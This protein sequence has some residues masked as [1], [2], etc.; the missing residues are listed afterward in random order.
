MTD[1]FTLTT[2]E[3]AQ[4]M[5]KPLSQNGFECVDALNLDGGSS[6][7]LSVKVGGFHLNISSLRPVAD[8]VLIIPRKN[9]N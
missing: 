4:I 9:F 1:H 5:K 3:L 2:T 7:Q 6:S 8:F